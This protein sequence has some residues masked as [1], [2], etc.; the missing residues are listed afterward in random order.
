MA[1]D[2]ELIAP[3]LAELALD[4]LADMSGRSEWAT[5]TA[6]VGSSCACALSAGGG[7]VAAA[8]AVS[9]LLLA[10]ELCGREASPVGSPIRK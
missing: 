9:L 6:C 10:S 1:A 2:E 8:A 7:A 3:V 4:W 5:E